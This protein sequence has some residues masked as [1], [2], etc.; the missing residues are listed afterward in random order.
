LRRTINRLQRWQVVLGAA[1]SLLAVWAILPTPGRLAVGSV[2]LLLPA[3]AI[4]IG[5]RRYRPQRTREWLVLAFGVGIVAFAGIFLGALSAARRFDS[6]WIGLAILT[7]GMFVRLFGLVRLVRGRGRL[8]RGVI[9]DIAV[10]ALAA[11]LL[12]WFE[13]IDPIGSAVGVM[14]VNPSS[15]VTS[16]LDVILFA[17]ALRLLLSSGRRHG[18]RRRAE[19]EDRLANLIHVV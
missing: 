17:L 6:L 1:G 5:V 15:V 8:D 4:P 16:G 9:I 7:V 13:L 14:N 2:L 3:I 19:F 18:A 10:V 12:I 11:G